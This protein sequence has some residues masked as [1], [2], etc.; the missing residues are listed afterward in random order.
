[1][2]LTTILPSFLSISLV[3][4]HFILPL[5]IF[6]LPFS[7][8]CALLS[9]PL[10]V[11]LHFHSYL[12]LCINFFF[13]FLLSY[14]MYFFYLFHITYILSLFFNVRLSLFLYSHFYIYFF[15]SFLRMC[16]RTN[17]KTIFLIE[18]AESHRWELSFA[19]NCL[20]WCLFRTHSKVR[21]FFIK[22]VVFFF[23]LRCIVT[24]FKELILEI[25]LPKLK[26]P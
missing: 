3:L 6:N 12:F 7:I 21:Q 24:G 10:T 18:V 26:F 25:R 19:K 9:L 5:F 20:F 23:S 1:M 22:Q 17:F 4:A 2:S 8:L 11:C 13:L 15:L 14:L 16:E